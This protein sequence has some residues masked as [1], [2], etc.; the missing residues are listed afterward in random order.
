M[1]KYAQTQYETALKR[2]HL[3]IDTIKFRLTPET[4]DIEYKDLICL[5]KDHFSAGLNDDEDQSIFYVPEQ[6]AWLITAQ[7][8]PICRFYHAGNYDMFVECFGMFQSYDG[9]LL[10]L[11][12]THA[13]IFDSIFELRN[14]FNISIYK[15]DF[16]IDYFYDFKKS[17]VWFY[18]ESEEN[19][20]NKIKKQKD[21]DI[22]Y[23]GRFPMHT[24]EVPK[25]R[26]DILN[27]VGKNY[28]KI[29]R[30]KVGEPR[31]KGSYYRFGIYKEYRVFKTLKECEEGVATHIQLK[32]NEKKLFYDVMR[33]FDGK[34]KWSYDFDETEDGR[35]SKSTPRTSWISY[36][37]TQRDRDRGKEDE[38]EEFTHEKIRMEY[39]NNDEEFAECLSVDWKHSRIELRSLNPSV[40]KD[41]EKHPD[42]TQE[43]THTN[44]FD[45]LKKK[46]KNIM[47][48]LIRP[49]VTNGVYIN[50]CWEMQEIQKNKH[51]DN[52]KKLQIKREEKGKKFKPSEFIPKQVKPNPYQHGRTLKPIDFTDSLKD[53]LDM[54]KSFFIKGTEPLI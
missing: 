27:F 38:A 54:I 31:P 49:D 12:E 35:V 46:L 18:E 33:L 15:L 51:V 19:N 3:G 41:G 5:L 47:I 30:K 37:K 52:Q 36:N 24:I 16:S 50:H 32:I 22:T 9:S 7:E 6:R 1:D 14:D 43:Q 42:V 40:V 28:R 13:K 29:K 45:F 10:Q 2:L 48:V 20:I 21:H 17:F 4:N 26:D 53:E 44:I 8:Y 39:S 34:E 23:L 25:K 11:N